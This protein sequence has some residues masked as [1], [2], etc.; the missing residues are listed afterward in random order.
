MDYTILQTEQFHNYSEFEVKTVLG[1]LEIFSIPSD[2]PM[3]D[4]SLVCWEYAYTD[5][6]LNRLSQQI[7][8]AQPKSI[9]HAKKYSR[10]PN[11]PLFKY[12]TSVHSLE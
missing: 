1:V 9:C 5:P 8:G 11:K 7:C 3:P 6:L 2:S 4:H 10:D 12:D